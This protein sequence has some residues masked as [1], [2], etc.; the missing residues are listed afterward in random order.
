MKKRFTMSKIIATFFGIGYIPFAPGTFG[1]IVAF[2]LYI[3]LTI[4]LSILKGGVANVVTSELI[5]AMLVVIVGLF[6]LGSWA[7]DQ[8][9]ND[10]GKNDP[11]EI[12]IDEV[13]G[14]L[15]AICLTLA[16][17]PYIGIEAIMKFKSYGI[18]EYYLGL[19]NLVSAF[20]LFRL[21]DITK[22]W[23]IDYID[24]NVKNGIGVMLDDVVAAIFAVIV[25]FFAL[26]AIID[27]L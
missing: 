15:L 25:H 14:Q 26:Y 12:V 9:S 5:N 13:V 18:D 20:I 10:I 24:K 23:P 21:F 17:L 7:A 2:P 6:F 1:S 19:L 11:K 8:Y 4:G 22:P 3:L 27:R 16:L